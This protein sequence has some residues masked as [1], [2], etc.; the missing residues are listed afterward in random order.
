MMCKDD[1]SSIVA[2]SLGWN[3]CSHAAYKYRDY[4]KTLCGRD[5]PDV[6]IIGE[7]KDGMTPSCKRCQ[8][9]LS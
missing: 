3:A 2:S 6:E 1:F 4:W 5:L 8:K 9:I 7:R